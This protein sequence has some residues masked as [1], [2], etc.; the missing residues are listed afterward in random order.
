MKEIKVKFCN[1]DPENEYSY[2]HF[3][4]KKLEKKYKL[5]F[6]DNPDYIF[7][8]ETSTD[9]YKYDGIKIFFTGE[10]ISPNFNDCDYAIS[11]DHVN[12]EDR[13]YR[14]PMYLVTVFY[15]KDDLL[16]AGDNYLKNKQN[17][18]KEDIKKKTDFCSFVYSNYRSD[19]NRK[20]LFDKISEY[21]KINSG[22]TYLNNTGSNIKN[23]LEFEMK[24]KFSIACENSSRSGYV[25][26][27][28]VGSLVANTIPIYWGSPSIGKEFNTKR[29][30]NCHDYESLDEILNKIKE[31]DENDDLY[32][33][34]INEPYFVDDF[35]YENIKNGF[36]L[37]L[38]NIINQPIDLAK[39]RTINPIKAL[40]IKEN[41]KMIE[42]FT[43]RKLLIRKSAAFLYKPF[44][45]IKLLEKIKHD[46]FSV[47]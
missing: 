17:F 18:T 41:E 44:K 38:E 36:D 43:K 42:K 47:K 9:H 31:F 19:N 8:N 35:D 11:Y 7:Y 21:K 26:E 16:L 40:E 28:I 12:F 34:T 4:I 1:H 2:G 5:N 45:K 23:K 27:K 25:T 24:H 3:F 20:R 29:F 6:S 14:L 30:I 33:K 39:R 13:H 32:I 15:N 46:Y 22:G 37:F 10:N